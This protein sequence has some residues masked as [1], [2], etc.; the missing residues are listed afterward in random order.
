MIHKKI[1][2]VAGDNPDASLER[3][4][5]EVSGASV[6]FVEQVL[7]EYGDPADQAVAA[8]QTDG[9]GY[10]STDSET[11][12]HQPTAGPED[13]TDGQDSDESDHDDRRE[14]TQ[15]TAD[16]DEESTEQEP[17]ESPTATTET[18]PAPITSPDQLTE[19]QQETLRAVAAEP[20]ATQEAVANALG[21]TRA[22]VS[23]RLGEVEGFDWQS[24][25]EFVDRVF[26]GSVTAGESDERTDGSETTADGTEDA[27]TPASGGASPEAI[28]DLQ[29]QVDAIETRLSDDGDGA[30]ES[31]GVD[32]E[33]VQKVVHACMDAEYVTQEEEL[34]VLGLFL[35]DETGH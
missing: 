25:A 23:R 20:D 19:K 16:R 31:D 22:T 13:A 15:M 8:S 32:A 6:T 18:E 4:A 34:E 29:A 12:G 3:I 14:A 26:D 24:R 28:A 35:G 21:V 33:L 5:D 2:D 7:D 17:A 10:D 30:D 9:T 11:N 1:L 27:A